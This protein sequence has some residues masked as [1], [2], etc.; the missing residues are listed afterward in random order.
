MRS[1]LVIVYPTNEKY[2]R[3]LEEKLAIKTQEK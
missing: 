2:Q 3:I 1:I